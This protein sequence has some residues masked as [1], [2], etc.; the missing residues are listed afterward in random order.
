MLIR[1]ISFRED[2]L[3][4]KDVLPSILLKITQKCLALMRDNRYKDKKVLDRPAQNRIFAKIMI[5]EVSSYPT[6]LDAWELLINLSGG[7]R[8]VTFL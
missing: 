3:V 2:S 1:Q 5:Q 6:R 7:R 4:T 8:C